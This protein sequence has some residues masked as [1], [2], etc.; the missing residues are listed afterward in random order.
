[1]ASAAV[2]TTTS[3]PLPS[4]WSSTPAAAIAVIASSDNRTRPGAT[5]GIITGSGSNDATTGEPMDSPYS[6][7][8]ACSGSKNRKSTHHDKSQRDSQ[9]NPLGGPYANAHASPVPAAEHLAT[10]QYLGGGDGESPLPPALKRI[11]QEVA[12]TGTCSWLFWDQEIND[13]PPTRGGTTAAGSAAAAGLASSFV[14]GSAANPAGV[15]QTEDS[16]TGPADAIKASPPQGLGGT[17]SA[18]GGPPRS[19]A[20]SSSSFGSGCRRSGGGSGSSP[21]KKHRNGIHKGTSASSCSRM[22]FGNLDGAS[23]LG[24]GRTLPLFSTSLG[25]LA[26]LGSSTATTMTGSAYA[27]APSLVGSGRTSGG[28]PDSN[29]THCECDSERTPATTN[30]EAGIERLRKSRQMA[31][32]QQRAEA[33]CIPSGEE[34]TGH[35]GVPYRTLQGAFRVALGLVLDH[36]Y[37]NLGGYKLSLAEE[38]RHRTLKTSGTTAG[39]SQWSE[40][41]LRRGCGGDK[42]DEFS[43]GSLTL[44][45]GIFQQRRQRLMMMLLPSSMQTDMNGSFPSMQTDMNGSFRRRKHPRGNDDPPFTIQRI[46]EVLVSP[47][48]VRQFDPNKQEAGMGLVDM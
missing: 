14:R 7:S 20:S 28:E 48:R 27:S 38:R 1:M 43:K 25:T 37:H 16:G 22:W 35:A 26:A 33:P 18:S 15:A 34:D 9:Q 30:S 10:G 5:S 40:N 21:R 41:Q 2:A 17:A 44:A 24:S 13:P 23:N 4:P 45:A 11:L 39:G 31:V 12:A 36:F 8:K 3:S 42:V 47:E 6:E 19:H 46:A 29:S 32:L